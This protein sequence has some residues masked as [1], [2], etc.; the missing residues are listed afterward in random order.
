MRVNYNSVTPAKGDLCITTVIPAK[1][2]LCTTTVVP[3]K[4]GTQGRGRGVSSLGLPT[5]RTHSDHHI[6][7]SQRTPKMGTS[8]GSPHGNPYLYGG[9][10]EY[11]KRKDRPTAP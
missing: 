4:T 10:Y 7:V 2:D 3:V 9:Q 1:G 5:P 6:R 8:K 11:C